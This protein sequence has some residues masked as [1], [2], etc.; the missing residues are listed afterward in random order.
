MAET[1]VL[2]EL[3]DPNTFNQII[4]FDI[5]FIS[6]SYDYKG[7][8]FQ[9]SKGGSI[10][11]FSPLSTRQVY[12]GDSTS[13]SWLEGEAYHTITF[14]ETPTGE[15]LTWLQANGVK[16][17]R[18]PANKVVVNGETI[19]DLTQDSVTPSSLLKGTTAHDKSGAPI[20][21]TM[22]A[23]AGGDYNIAATTNSDGTQSLAITDAGGGSSGGGSGSRPEVNLT[24]T[25]DPTEAPE[26]W[27]LDVYSTY[28][29]IVELSADN[30]VS[31]IPNCT[32]G[33]LFIISGRYSA[34]PSTTKGY[35]DADYIRPSCV[36][37]GFDFLGSTGDIIASGDAN[38]V[39]VCQI[40]PDAAAGAEAT[41][42]LKFNP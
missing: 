13:G 34:T 26:D 3:V 14:L 4:L 8:E 22:E 19:L 36:N 27:S 7:I 5:H 9:N 31:T 6:N 40:D 15:L 18:R 35:L 41:M 25:V 17:Q 28:G 23:S 24:I 37:C 30:L 2:N 32:V 38:P 11:Y 29:D 20:T 21:G 33:G 1:W 12:G 16:Q 39:Y 42:T 10:Y